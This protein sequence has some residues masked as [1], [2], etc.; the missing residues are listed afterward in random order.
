MTQRR[1]ERERDQKKLAEDETK[2]TWTRVA[3]ET[4]NLNQSK[5]EYNLLRDMLWEQ[6]LEEKQKKEEEE[7]ILCKMELKENTLRQ[8][9]EQIEA[10]KEML[11]NMEDEECHLVRQMLDKF[12]RDEEDEESRQRAI[13]DAKE[14]FMAEAQSQ[15]DQRKHMFKQ[16]KQ[17][18]YQERHAG[19]EQEEYRQRVIAEARKRLLLGHAAQVQG[20]LPKGAIINEDE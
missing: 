12:R 19:V 16:E 17:S 14:R 5:E 4:Q 10:K 15:R 18:E 8:N 13:F 11:K 1:R 2:R 9:L 3:K 7:A 6:E 20:F